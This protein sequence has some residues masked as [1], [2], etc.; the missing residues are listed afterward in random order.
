MSLTKKQIKSIKTFNAFDPSTSEFT[1]SMLREA[2]GMDTR[3]GDKITWG[4]ICHYVFWWF[5]LFSKEFKREV[6]ENYIKERVEERHE[7]LK[8]AT[9]LVN[10]DIADSIVFYIINRLY[11]IQTDRPHWEVLKEIKEGEF[12]EFIDVEE[13]LKK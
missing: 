5:N 12:N 11:Y 9:D 6:R 7:S 2:L 1:E 3:N 4:K 8:E 10:Y 13:L